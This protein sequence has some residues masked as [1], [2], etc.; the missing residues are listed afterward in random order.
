MSGPGTRG[1]VTGPVVTGPVVTVTLN[2]ALDV[3]YRVARLRAGT[4]HRVEE[5][6]ERAGGKGVNVAAVL[7][8]SGVPVLATG[9]LAGEAG[10]RVRADLDARGVPHRFVD[11]PGETRRT[12]TVVE[13]AGGTGDATALNEP[14]PVVGP[15]DAA[16]ALDELAAVLRDA[17][18]AVVVVSGSLPPGLDEAVVARLLDVAAQLGAATVLDTG[19]RSLLRTLEGL[20]DAGAPG[21]DVVKPNRPELAELLAV[22]RTGS[23]DEQGAEE[24]TDESVAEGAGVALLRR[25]G[26]RTVVVSSGGAGLTL[27]PVDGPPLT[28]RLP[29]PLTGHPTG[30]GDAAVA[31]LAAGLRAGAPWADVAA[32]AV[33]RSA[34]A[35]LRPVAGEVDPADVAR[36]RG[37]VVLDGA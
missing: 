34:A 29:Q 3:T 36:L 30:A 28:A 9:L 16:R 8:G 14:G 5:V 26:A 19:G 31:A 23:S 27:H 17:R 7:H 12:L 24:A 15:S 21:P 10:R 1:R 25:L 35:V 37:Q 2:A 6:L 33:A 18:P 20:H 4:S 13:G 22:A 32:D 11:V